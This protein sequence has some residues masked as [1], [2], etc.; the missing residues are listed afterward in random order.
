MWK[1]TID[2]ARGVPDNMRSAVTAPEDTH[3]E[4]N[5]GMGTV[6]PPDA[7]L[8]SGGADTD[9]ETGGVDHQDEAT[10]SSH[11]LLVEPPTNTELSR[12]REDSY[13]MESPTGLGW[14]GGGGAG[15]RKV[16]PLQSRQ[17]RQAQG[18]LF[19]RKR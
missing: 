19:Q 11:P 17:C 4:Q 9:R 2:V 14:G 7:D 8:H 5:M 6:F 15:T 13:P 1:T 3:A 12:A 18:E 10:D 16:Y